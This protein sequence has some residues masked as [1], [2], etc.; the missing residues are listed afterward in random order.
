MTRRSR[1]DQRST[2]YDQRRVE[3][4]TQLWERL[5]SIEAASRL[6]QVPESGFA[7][8]IKGLND[9]LHLNTP[10]LRQDEQEWARAC[11]SSLQQIEAILDSIPQDTLGAYDMR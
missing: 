11:L 6:R 10:V 3:A 4:L 7:E 2:A 5:Q 9:F 8:Q 1:S